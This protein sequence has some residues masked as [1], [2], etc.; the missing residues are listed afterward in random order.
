ML[1]TWMH[2]NVAR[3]ALG[4]FVI[5][6]GCG[7]QVTDERAQS[8][9]TSGGASAT[10]GVGGAQASSSSNTGGGGCEAPV[11]CCDGQGNQ[12]DPIC[13]SG[14]PLCPPGSDWPPNGVCPPLAATC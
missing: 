10:S 4:T 5:V 8:S 14:A 6:A 7:E 3:G 9:A 1:M 12:V 11:P 13:E 2:R